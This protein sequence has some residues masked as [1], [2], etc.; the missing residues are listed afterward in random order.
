MSLKRKLLS[1]I[2]IVSLGF[3]G[4]V[5]LEQNPVSGNKRAYGYSWEQEVQIG[6]ESDPE[7]IAQYGLYENEELANYVSQLGQELVEVSHLRRDD[8]PEKFKNTP[9]TFR[10]LNSPVVNAFA[11]P[12]GYIYVTRGLLGHLNNEA[13]LAVVLGHEI[14][15]VAAR[16]ASQRAMQQQFGQLAIIG[17]AVLG[18]SFGYDGQSILQLSSQ[19]AQLMFLKYGRDDERESDALGVEYA[20][21][22]HYEASEG[23]DFFTSLK[24]ISETQGGGI[25]TLLSSHPDPGERESTIPRLAQEWESKGYEQNILDKEE[26]MEMIEGI[27]YGDNPREGFERDGM[28]YHPDLEF[29][30]PVPNGFQLI[31]QT[32]AVIMVNEAQDAIIQFTIDNQNETPESSVRTFLAQEGITVIEQQSFSANSMNG[33]Q[34]IATAQ[35]QDG[36]ELK[37]KLTAVGY[38]GNIYRFL[39]YTTSAQ[40]E[41]YRDRFTTV[42]NGFS[43]LYDN[44][45]LGIQ[46][47]KLKLITT[48]RTAP[49]SSFLPNEL[50]MDIKPLDIA[51]INQVDLDQTIQPGTMLKIPVQ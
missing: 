27:V 30:F 49:F 14:G 7:I 23:A 28:F 25:P 10:V 16:H 46:P 1:V 15:H 39:S 2:V 17:G 36:T 45:I 31:N 19:T 47:V 21:M 43:Q 35:S 8:T 11:L 24:R 42:E 9:F 51:I 22:R 33:Y 34:G 44:A 26:F 6:K 38:G 48:S 12:G 13:Q 4:C 37:L 18:E 5:T 29:R 20:A 40:F 41:T 3:G 50:P 32:T